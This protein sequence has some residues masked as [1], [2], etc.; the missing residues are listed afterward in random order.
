[1]SALIS[2][3]CER[4]VL[5]IVC[6]KLGENNNSVFDIYIALK[7]DEAPVKA[8]RETEAKRMLEVEVYD[9]VSEEVAS[10][11]RMWN[12]TLLD[13]QQN[14]GSGE[15]DTCGQP[16]PR[17]MQ[18]R[19][20][21]CDHTTICTDELHLVACCVSWSWP[22][23]RF[24]AFFHVS[25]VEEVS[26]RPPKSLKNDK[27]IWK[28]LKLM[29][30]T[31]DATQGWCVKQCATV[32]GEFSPAC[33]VLLTMRKKTRCCY[34][35]RRLERFPRLRPTTGREGV[36]CTERYGGTNLDS[37]I[38]QIPNTWTR[39]SRFRRRKM[40]HLFK[41]DTGKGQANTL[42]ELSL[43]EKGFPHV[44]F[45]LVTIH[46][47]GLNGV[48]HERSEI[49]NGESRFDGTV[50]VETFGK[51]LGWTSRGFDEPR[52]PITD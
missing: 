8:G 19:R 26:V 27:I 44:W 22:L 12:N 15:V 48:C 40:Q 21:V 17:C 2:E 18:T 47:N 20:R 6:E 23:L 16:S 3:L 42:C 34:L 31:Q 30:G 51:L 35:R 14:S 46:R 1:M 38:D 4:D 25:M 11:T 28:F 43:T 37:R 52:Q 33:R 32:T 50:I 49:A 41:R 29:K 9:D 39:W 5:E 10:G 24:V 7:I 36:F 45:K 13:S